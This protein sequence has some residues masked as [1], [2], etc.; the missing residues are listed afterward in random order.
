MSF[1]DQLRSAP[2]EK[3]AQKE[4]Q[5]KSASELVMQIRGYVLQCIL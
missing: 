5:K 1:A 2:D 3:K 4:K